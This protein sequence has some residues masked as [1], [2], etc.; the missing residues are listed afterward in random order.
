MLDN[1]IFASLGTRTDI[2][3]D[4]HSDPNGYVYRGNVTM[5]PGLT[6][7]AKGDYRLNATSPA[8]SGSVAMPKE[9]NTWMST[10]GLLP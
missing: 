5:D 2:R 8:F 3:F 4:D 7:E 1:V 6:D 10:A 9:W